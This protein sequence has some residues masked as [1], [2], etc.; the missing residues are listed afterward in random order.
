MQNGQRTKKG[1]KRRL[2]WAI[3]FFVMAI[4]AAAALFFVALSYFQNAEYQRAENRASLY[5]STLVGAL[6]RSEYL[7][8]IL[9]QDPYVIA[10]AQGKDLLGLNRR[11]AEFAARANLDAIY[12]MDKTGLTI[13]AS[14]YDAPV[15]FIGQNYGFRPYFKDA[16]AGKRG[17]FFGIGATTLQP[18]YFIAE[19][20]RG[21]RGEALGVIA[22][23]LNLTDLTKAWAAG[24]EV[25]FVSN[26]DGVVVLS[27]NKD[28]R[29]KT[30]APISAA[31]R[32][33]I[34]KERQFASEP[35]T[36][37]GWKVAGNQRAR[38]NGRDYIYAVTPVLRPGWEL[39]FLS[40]ES[41]VRERAWFTVIAAAILASLPLMVALFFRAERIRAALDASQADRRQLR[42]ANKKLAREIEE[43]RAAERRLEKAQEELARSSKLAALGQLSASVTHELGQ[44]ISAMRNYLAAAEYDT[45]KKERATTLKRLSEIVIRMVSITNQ[46]R[47]FASPG[48]SGLT[49]IDLRKVWQGALVLIEPDIKVAKIRL[50]AQLWH[51]PVMIR[52]NRLRLEQVLVNLLRNAIAAMIG[53]KER[54]LGVNI[55]VVNGRAVISVSDS[56]HGLGERSIEQLKE[57]FHTTRASGDGMGLGLAISAAIV[58]EH[59][60]VLQAQNNKEGGAVFCV[61]LPLADGEI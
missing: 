23:K 36:T 53:E 9:S 27:S 60:G 56:G 33:E 25:V 4:A 12:L 31:R 20:V 32:A 52:G 54:T 55:G 45:N 38:L 39:H 57:P 50:D 30:L 37:L 51:S 21:A 58:K 11:L 14:N 17:E 59:G 28:W 10:G 6:G 2:G 3:A 5:R 41:R 16:M 15:T 44:P 8:F 19:M 29:Y 13:A 43:R 22:I 24:G 40:D 48:D 7:P 46:L 34:A 18:G 49:R 42:S 47:F 61:E 1:G 26:S 35:L